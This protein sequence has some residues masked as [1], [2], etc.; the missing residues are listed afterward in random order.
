MA[1]PY[2]QKYNNFNGPGHESPANNIIGKEIAKRLLKP[3][4]RKLDDV[5]SATKKGA[6]SWFGPVKK[7]MD[8]AIDW[9]KTKQK[10]GYMTGAGIIY[11]QATVKESER[12]LYDTNEMIQDNPALNQSRDVNKTIDFLTSQPKND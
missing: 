4:G 6:Q 8:T 1:H 10:Y 7:P 2:K 5:W 12:E 11:D 3:I 9:K